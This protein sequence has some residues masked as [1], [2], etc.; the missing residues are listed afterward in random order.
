MPLGPSANLCVVRGECSA[1]PEVREL[2]S[3]ARLA[4]VSVRVNA[5]GGRA[6]SVPV[7]W[8]EP[9]AWFEEVDAGDELVVVGRVR[10]RF[11]GLAGGGRGA[12]VEVEADVVARGGDG[13]RVSSALRRAER[14]LEALMD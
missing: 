1:C 10:R 9:P 2:A 8:W 13:R 3:G 5:A 6:T 14:T 4:A 7:V 11:F 12:R